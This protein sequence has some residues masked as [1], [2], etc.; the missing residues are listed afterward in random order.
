MLVGAGMFVLCSCTS[1]GS[2]QKEVVADS[3]SVSQVNP[4]VETIMSR[5]SIRKYKPEAVEREKMQT[6]VECGINAPN[7]MNKQSWEVRVVDNPEFINGLT[8]I[9]KKENPKAAERPGFKNMFN[10]APTCLLY[11]SP[12]PRDTR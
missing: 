7:G 3:V 8:E 4:V 2:R 11:T 9:F 1:Q 12:S 6:I 5:R 10:N